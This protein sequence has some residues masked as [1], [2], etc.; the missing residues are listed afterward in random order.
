[1]RAKKVTVVTQ[2]QGERGTRVQEDKKSVVLSEHSETL[3]KQQQRQLRRKRQH[4]ILFG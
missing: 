1:M 4:I 2:D 3:R